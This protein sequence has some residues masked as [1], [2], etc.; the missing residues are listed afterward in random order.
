MHL[1]CN[2]LW[3]TASKIGKSDKLIINSCSS[4]MG[5]C[6]YSYGPNYWHNVTK[7]IYSPLPIGKQY[8]YDRV[9]TQSRKE[10]SFYNLP[11]LIGKGRGYPTLNKA[12]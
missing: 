12:R 5:Y 10:K 1:K 11:A 7:F 8:C 6:R 3:E 9:H 2:N 4:S